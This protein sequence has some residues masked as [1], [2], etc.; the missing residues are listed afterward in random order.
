MSDIKHYEPLWG[1]WYIDSLLGEGGFGK[2]Y[3]VR[4]E[5]FGKTYYSAVKIISV[6]NNDAE[7]RQIKSEG[8]DQDS[9][10]KFL[11]AFVTDIITEID[12]MGQL[13]GN[14][15]IV[16]L[17]DHQVIP[18]ADGIGWD[19]LMRMELLTSL[20]DHIERTPPHPSQRHQV[21]HS[22]LPG[23]RAVRPEKHHTPRHQTRQ[24]LYLLLQRIQAGRLR[25]SPAS[26]AHLVRAF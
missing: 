9:I 3:K 5:Q 12:L 17:E 24:H 15:N 13:K 8:L 19:I 11:Y 4:Q 16:T 10:E 22:H 20:T 14:S 25:G 7:L 1:T 2:V 23:F 21:R 6:P 26:G 18:K